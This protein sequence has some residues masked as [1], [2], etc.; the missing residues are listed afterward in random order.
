MQYPEIDIARDYPTLGTN[1]LSH[2][3]VNGLAGSIE[4]YL[5]A[6]VLRDSDGVLALFNGVRTWRVC[7]PTKVKSWVRPGLSRSSPTRCS[8]LALMHQTR[9]DRLERARSNYR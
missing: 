9:L 3:D 2:M 4:L 5:G 1:G 8:E 7:E 6:D